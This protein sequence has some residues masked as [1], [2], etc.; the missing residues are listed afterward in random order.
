MAAT[1]TAYGVVSLGERLA[2]AE[3]DRGR[4]S[5]R[6]DLDIGAFGVNAIYQRKAGEDIIREHHEAGPGGD[7]HEELYVVVQGSATFT[8]DGEQVEA[9]QGTAIF[10]RE[11]GVLRAAVATAADT[12]VLAAGGPRDHGYRLTPAASAVGFWPA[13]RDKDYAAALEA[14]KRGLETYPGNAYLL[15]NVACMESLLG[16][17]D[18]ALTAL[19][20]SVAQWE[21]YKE[22][23]RND[24]DFASLREDPRFV[25]LVG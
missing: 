22:Q 8:V 23:A 3:D 14:T 21:Q 15:Y 2:E 19:A 13:Y 9:P 17:D 24:D 5:L 20:E 12:I 18:A 6:E 10:V 7:R 16:N 11:P 25:K 4:V 1:Q